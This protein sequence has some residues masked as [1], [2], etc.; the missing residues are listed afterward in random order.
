MSAVI[1]PPP[2]RF[3]FGLTVADLDAAV[4]FYEIL[5][6]V[7]PV[8]F[9]DDYAKFEVHD[10]PLVLA[11]HP[12]QVATTGA[13][14]HVG[15]RV[16][17]AVALVRVQQRLEASGITTLREDQVEC[18]YALQTKFWVTDPDS[19]MWEVYTLEDDLQ[20][21]GFGGAELHPPAR[22]DLPTARVSWQHMLTAPLPAR[23][24]FDD[25]TVDDVILEGTFNANLTASARAQFLQEVLRAL[26]PGGKIAVHGLV[27][28]RPF[29]GKPQ[30]PGPAAMVQVIPVEEEPAEELATAG[31]CGLHYDKLGDIH[32]FSVHGVELRELRLSAYKPL[33]IPTSAEFAVLYRGPLA[34]VQDER[35]RTYPRGRRIA[36]DEATWQL[37]QQPLFAEH[38]T[39]LA[40]S[41]HD[42]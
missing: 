34:Q 7:A 19:H 1:A 3:H 18:C 27:G 41:P 10:P 24:P 40:P 5:L 33:S 29:P 28:D 42:A 14:N 2:Q 15:F 37:F 39:C 20:H 30:L 17:D 25:G 22:P 6:G 16:A 23:L 9:L 13:L 35:G 21:S 36:V 12:G 4:R 38:F 31:F 32:C 11:L 8:K 26:R